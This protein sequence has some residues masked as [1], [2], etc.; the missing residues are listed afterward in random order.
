MARRFR[1]CPVTGIDWRLAYQ[2]AGGNFSNE[3]CSLDIS[4]RNARCNG[5]FLRCLVH[6]ASDKFRAFE[7]SL[8]DTLYRHTYEA[9]G[10]PE[11]GLVS[12]DDA[13]DIARREGDHWLKENSP[14]L[15][16]LPSGFQVRRWDSWRNHTEFEE[17]VERVSRLVRYDG[18]VE[19]LSRDVD[20]F[21][22][23]RDRDRH[24]AQA[25]IGLERFIVEE[26]AVYFLHSRDSNVRHVYPGKSL[27]VL[28]WLTKHGAA[29]LAADSAV[30]SV[31]AGMKRADIDMRD[32]H[33]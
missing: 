13:E 16:E 7:V 33:D 3:I 31:L 28:S 2:T 1:P 17:C 14:I 23:R 18:I 11:C 15:A 26:V 29:V 6:W 24:D 8:G 27:H 5:Q 25:R 20:A 4:L 9:L 12:A 22:R 32:G 21:L 19:A 30:V 10:H